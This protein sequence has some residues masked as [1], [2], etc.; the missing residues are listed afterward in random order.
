MGAQ[1]NSLALDSLGEYVTYELFD[2]ENDPNE[3]HN[4]LFDRAD[5]PAVAAKFAE[6]KAE[7][8]RLQREFKDDGLYADPATWPKSS[9]DGPFEGKEPLGRKTVREAIALSN[10]K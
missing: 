3:Q 2:L 7:I 9:S 4:L 1:G 6:L 5:D 10:S 8:E